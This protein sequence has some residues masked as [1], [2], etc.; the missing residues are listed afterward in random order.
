[1]GGMDL[2]QPLVTAAQITVAVYLF[3]QT[4]PHREHFV[5][6]VGVAVAV[7]LLVV[8]ASTWVGDVAMP[9]LTG[10]Y[11]YQTQFLVFS[12]V[13]V[14]AVG[15]VVFL[16]DTSVWPALFCC[17]AGYTLQNLV[18]GT[19][20]LADLLLTHAFGAKPGLT[21][22][23]LAVSFSIAATCVIYLGCYLLLIRKIERDGL[24]LVEDKAMLLMCAVVILGVIGFDLINKALTAAGTDFSY[25]VAL[26][27]V[28]AMVCVFTLVMEYELLYNRHLQMDVASVS[29]ILADEE[30]Q[31]RVSKENIDAINVK[32]HDIRHQI[33]HLEGAGQVVDKEVLDDIA[34]EVD[35]YDST[36]KTG[37]DALDVILTEKSLLCEREGIA[38]SCIADGAA[39]SFMD[40]PDLYALFGNALDNALGAVQAIPETGR[41]SI[42]LMVRRNAG[43]ACVHVENCFAGELTFRDGLPQTTQTDTTSH[44]FGMRSMAHIA[45]KYQ[46]TL[47]CSTTDEVFSLN[48]IMPIPE[49]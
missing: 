21:E 43:M 37:N 18:S 44:G 36:V 25:L 26:R 30:K 2:A 41:R 34:R 48:V 5:V 20:G 27:L 46:G 17:T 45:E 22:L 33:R 42:S 6:R 16:F 28:H 32:C 8:V 15:V 31:Y 47:A 10:T 14:F 35:V 40:A 4:L 12:A 3:A 13:L 19:E 38:L 49:G 11:A 23:P 29:R 7:T 39:L 24:S 1:M 9:D